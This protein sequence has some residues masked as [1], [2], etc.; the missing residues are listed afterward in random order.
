VRIAHHTILSSLSNRNRR[1]HTVMALNSNLFLEI[2]KLASYHTR[3]VVHGCSCSNP[4]ASHLNHIQVW[5][6]HGDKLYRPQY[7]SLR[8]R[9]SCMPHVCKNC[10][11]KP[12]HIRD[13]SWRCDH[14]SFAASGM[15]EYHH[16][17][18]ICFTMTAHSTCTKHDWDDT[19]VEI[20]IQFTHSAS[21]LHNED[22]ADIEAGQVVQQ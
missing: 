7:F 16:G 22:Y 9:T 11:K 1:H 4:T 8:S 5:S 17:H 13:D 21:C 2:S 19:S 3:Y 14:V 12:K 18:V 15:C 20:F 10:C 6:V